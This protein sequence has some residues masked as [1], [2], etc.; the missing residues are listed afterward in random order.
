[1]VDKRS[2]PRSVV[3]LTVHIRIEENWV[4]A[5]IIDLTVEG[6][7]ME[8]GSALNEGA[9]VTIEIQENKDIKNS[10]LEIKT[11]RCFPIDGEPKKYQLVAQFVDPNDEFLMDVLA[12]VHGSGP[13]KDRRGTIYER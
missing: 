3:D 13:K 12:L 2:F 4:E 6:I 8:I 9:I 1:M 5:K 11:I 7:C 10:K